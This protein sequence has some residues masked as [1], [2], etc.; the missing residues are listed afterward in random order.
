[1]LNKVLLLFILLGSSSLAWC[2]HEEPQCD[3]E[4]LAEVF[5]DAQKI[6]LQ[7]R[8]R[9]ADHEWSE[10]AL[11]C[12]DRPGHLNQVIVATF[13]V[14]YPPPAEFQEKD[15]GFAV[16]VVDR[17]QRRLV[18]LHTSKFLEDGGTNA[19]WPG[20]LTLDAVG[21]AVKKSVRAI[22]VRLDVVRPGCAWE[23]ASNNALWLFVE[24][25]P[26]LQPVLSGLDMHRSQR[27]FFKGCICCSDKESR[28]AVHDGLLTLSIASTSTNGYRDLAV[29]ANLSSTEYNLP[30]NNTLG[31]S[32]F[33]GFIKFDGQQYRAEGVER[34]LGELLDAR[35][36]KYEKWR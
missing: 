31:E 28:G 16:A 20:S 27:Q 5:G 18:S 9:K 35:M 13:F 24:R 1:M 36:Q 3:R 25:G 14:P 23:G 15:V 26:V 2:Q 4:L 30:V 10:E 33:V 29:R 12:T 34:R 7:G 22:G 32:A 8:G 19:F 21:Y 11:T 17:V 6:T